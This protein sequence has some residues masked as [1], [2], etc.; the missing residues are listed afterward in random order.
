LDQAAIVF[1][2]AVEEF[3]KAVLLRDA[4]QTGADPVIVDGFYDHAAKL[5]G[6]GKYIPAENLLVS[7]SAFQQGAFQD[8]AYEVGESA[9]LETRLSSLY[10]D[11]ENGWRHGVH[12]D[13]ELLQRNITAVRFRILDAKIEWSRSEM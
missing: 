7:Q 3:G 5:E 4:Y 1:S 2:F 13:G 12:V 6:A 8:D 9:D 11:W 10:V